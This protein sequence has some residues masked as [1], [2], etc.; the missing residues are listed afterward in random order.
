MMYRKGGKPYRTSP[1]PFRQV[2]LPNFPAPSRYHERKK[3]ESSAFPPINATS[4]RQ[5]PLVGGDVL[6]APL[7]DVR[8]ARHEIAAHPWHTR[9]STPLPRTNPLS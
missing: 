2:H 8:N 7:S 9:P 5:S 1:F 6:G 4:P 3:E